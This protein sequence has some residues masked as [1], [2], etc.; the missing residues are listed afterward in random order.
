MGFYEEIS[1]YYDILFPVEDE[2]VRFISECAGQSGNRILDV[3]CGAGGYAA[4]LA[5]KG[6]AVT[7]VDLDAAMVQTARKKMESRGLDGTVMQSDMK[8]LMDTVKGKYQSVFCI[9]NSIVHLGSTAEILKAL[10][11]MYRLLEESGVLVLQIINYDRVLKYGINELPV[12]RNEEAGIEF[13][14][15]YEYEKEKGILHFNTVLRIAQ[16]EGEQVLENSVE[17]LPLASNKMME[18]LEQVRFRKIQFYGDFAKAPY[19]DNSYM[20]V[21]KAV[22]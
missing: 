6:Y 21:A 22:K 9:G 13:T 17:L 1:K 14:R 7:A 16:D 5:E 20:L 3:A 4:A 15:K 10:Q 19:T 2:Q 11:Q 8:A 12:I 18:L